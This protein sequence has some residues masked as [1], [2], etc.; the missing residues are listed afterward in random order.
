MARFNTDD[1]IRRLQQQNVK[2]TTQRRI[3]LDSILAYP[4]THFS[5]EQLFG[6]IQKRHPSIGIATVFRSLPL[7]EKSGIISKV[8]FEDKVSLYELAVPGEHHHHHLVCA[9][10]GR[11]IEMEIDFLDRLEEIVHSRY[12]FQILDHRLDF[13]GVC[14]NC[15]VPCN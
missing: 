13:F 3:I 4:D 11:I 15:Q 6:F 12:D 8:S 9:S 14:S 7:F 10:C 2:I 5:T 1:L